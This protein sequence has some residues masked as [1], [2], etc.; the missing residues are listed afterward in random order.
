MAAT[1]KTV[2]PSQAD[3]AQ[4]LLANIGKATPSGTAETT[5]ITDWLSDKMGAP[6][7][8]AA[9]IGAASTVAFSNATAAYALEKQVQAAR[10]Q[11]QLKDMA[12]QAA[13][14]ILALQ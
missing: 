8:A 5:P 3:L 10:A 6:V 4:A 13:A 1:T 11:K 12:E 2:A 9:R 14:R 7:N